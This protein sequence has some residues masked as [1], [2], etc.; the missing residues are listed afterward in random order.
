[1]RAVYL[2]CYDICD[3]RRLR[4]VYKTMRG[5]GDHIQ[6]S[7]FRCELSARERID[8]I[9]ALSAVINHDED[10]VLIVDLGPGDGRAS[11]CFLALGKPYTAP[12]RVAIIA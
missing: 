9:G 7:V 5:F 3:G 6:L 2:V 8:L 4:K 11:S 1:M 10:Q 12:D